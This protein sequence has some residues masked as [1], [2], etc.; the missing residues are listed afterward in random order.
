MEKKIVIG[1]LLALIIGVLIY[2]FSGTDVPVKPEKKTATATT[3]S[4][5]VNWQSS[6]ADQSMD[7]TSDQTMGVKTKTPKQPNTTSKESL[8][9]PGIVSV[10]KND[11]PAAKVNGVIITVGSI[12]PPGVGSDFGLPKDTYQQ[13]LE[14][15]IETELLVQE[16]KKRGLGDKPEFQDM[17]MRFEEAMKKMYN[18]TDPNDERVKWQVQEFTNSSLV[19]ELYKEEGLAAEKVTDEEVETYY[20]QNSADYELIRKRGR[21]NGRSPDKIE[22]AVKREVESDLKSRRNKEVNKKRSAFS[23]T[24]RKSAK[25]EVLPN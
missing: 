1:S 9:M 7:S 23:A 14:R 8:P 24:L 21:E 19:Q 5:P 3:Q 11:K 4:P 6:K 20:Q 16:A 10:A 15:Q 12:A 25:I 2:T 18:T 22:K 13:L 17:V